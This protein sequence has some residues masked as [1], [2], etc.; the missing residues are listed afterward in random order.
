VEHLKKLDDLK[1]KGLITEDEY[2]RKWEEI[3]NELEGL[4]SPPVKKGSAAPSED[5]SGG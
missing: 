5:Q 4:V 1:A 2:K 3:L